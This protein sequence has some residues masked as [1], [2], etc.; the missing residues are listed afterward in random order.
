MSK[1][2][3]LEKEDVMD[4]YYKPIGNFSPDVEK[5]INTL[6]RKF[7]LLYLILC[8]MVA[9]FLGYYMGS[10]EWINYMI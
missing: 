2:F 6:D 8:A 1:L 10:Q 3:Q 7:Y 4:K 5:A 9:P